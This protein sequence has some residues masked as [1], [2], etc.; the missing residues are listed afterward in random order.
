MSPSED[1]FCQVG[2]TWWLLVLMAALGIGTVGARI[3]INDE[4]SRKGAVRM[5]SVMAKFHSFA[6]NTAAN[7]VATAAVTLAG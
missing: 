4:F 3:N 1:G 6:G 7:V 5:R 2:R